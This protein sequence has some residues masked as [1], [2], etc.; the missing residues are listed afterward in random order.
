MNKISKIL[1][2]ILAVL[3]A[4]LFSADFFIEKHEAHFH[5]EEFPGF[6]A[7][8]GFIAFVILVILSKYVLRPLVSRS[9]D[10]YE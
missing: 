7:V 8:Y 2:T 5:Y 1:F 3:G 9:E 10:F 4:I 6:Y